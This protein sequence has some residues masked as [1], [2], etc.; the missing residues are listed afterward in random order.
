MVFVRVFYHRYVSKG[1]EKSPIQTD[2]GDIS[3]CQGFKIVLAVFAQGAY[4]IVRQLAAFID[5]AT[6]AAY[7]TLLIGFGLG[8]DV[9]EVVAV[10]HGFQIAQICALGHIADEHDVG[11]QIHL[12]DD[13]AAQISIGILGKEQQTVGRALAL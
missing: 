4:Q 12:I 8:F 5:P 6:D 10:G 9:L 13:G 3:L 2:R 11:T 1:T 7:I